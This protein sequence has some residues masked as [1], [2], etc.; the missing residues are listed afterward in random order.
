MTNADLDR[1]EAALDFKLPAFY[2]AYMRNYPRWLVPLI[3]WT[4]CQEVESCVR[5]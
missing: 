2:R 3:F 1:I 4:F 5:A